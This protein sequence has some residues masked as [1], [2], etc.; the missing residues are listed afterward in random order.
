MVIF[1]IYNFEIIFILKVA[2]TFLMW[3]IWIFRK[4]IF[5]SA[6]KGLFDDIYVGDVTDWKIKQS[7]NAK[8]KC[9]VQMQSSNVK[10]KGKVQR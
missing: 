10:F 3:W 5:Y 6:F 2:I 9:K 8:F 7:S 4:Y 1:D